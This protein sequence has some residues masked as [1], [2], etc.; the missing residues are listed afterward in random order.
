MSTPSAAAPPEPTGASSS[1][2]LSAEQVRRWKSDGWLYLDGLFPDDLLAVAAAQAADFYPPPGA[3]EAEAE[4]LLYDGN[5]QKAFTAKDMPAVQAIMAASQAREPTQRFPMNKE[6]LSALNLTSLELRLLSAAAQLLF[7]GA[8]GAEHGLRLERSDLVPT[9]D[10]ESRPLQPVEHTTNLVPQPADPDAVE[11]VLFFDDAQFAAGSALVMR[12]DLGFAGSPVPAGTRRLTQHLILRK[13][14]AEYVQS[15]AFI[16]SLSGHGDLMGKLMPTQ[17][18]AL[19]FPPP[20]HAYWQSPSALALAIGRYPDFD[21]TPYI[22]CDGGAPADFMAQ[23]EAGAG[24]PSPQELPARVFDKEYGY[25]GERLAAPELAAGTDGKVLSD[26]QVQRW[27]ET[28]YVFISGIWPDEVM[29]A[30]ASAA[31]DLAPFPLEDGTAPPPKTGGGVFG[32]GSTQG[33]GRPGAFPYLLRTNSVEFI[34]H[35]Y[36]T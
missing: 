26:E 8:P 12:T 14:E 30:A 4:P 25:E 36:T 29:D 16:R 31:A 18:S 15:D 27:R 32:N 19:G 34:L 7:G 28:G 17:R 13:N 24:H 20:G 5:V 35:N 22:E 3:A 23:F 2:V 6:A 9:R 21:P 11:V 33:N 1:G 10:D